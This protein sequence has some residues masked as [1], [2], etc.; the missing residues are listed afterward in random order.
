MRQKNYRSFVVAGFVVLLLV[1]HGCGKK[2]DPCVRS[3]SS[4]EAV[5]DLRASLEGDSV[6]LSWT[7]TGEVEDIGRI[8]ILR[9]GIRVGAGECPGCPRAYEQIADVNPEDLKTMGSGKGFSYRDYSVERG[10]DYLYKIA[11]DYSDGKN[12]VE[13]TTAEVTFE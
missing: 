4:P 10:Y 9:N 3:V 8:R 5:S 12:G 11:V 1:I 7:A 2:G 6:R 13:S